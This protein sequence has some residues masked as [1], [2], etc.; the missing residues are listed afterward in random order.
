VFAPT[1]MSQTPSGEP[2]VPATLQRFSAD[3][4]P[5]GTSVSIHEAHRAM[6]DRGPS[7]L[8]LAVETVDSLGR[9]T[10]SGLTDG[11][12]YVAYAVVE[13]KHR[14]LRFR[15]EASTS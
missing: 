1:V 9:F 6:A 7:G 4:F 12:W 14:Y 5:P 15:Y 8:P 2:E 13:S 3:V 11:K 10:A